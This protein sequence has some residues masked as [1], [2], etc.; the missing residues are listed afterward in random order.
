MEVAYNKDNKERI[1]FEHYL[2][3]YKSADPQEICART[4]IQYNGEGSYFCLKFLG[5]VYHIGY[6][7]FSITPEAGEGQYFPLLSISAARTLVIRYIL[8]GCRA[9][10]TGKYLTY[11][12]V[13]WGEVYYRQFNG[14]CMMR[15]AYSYG[16][17]LDAFCSAMEKLGAHS[18]NAGDA[19]YEIEVFD[20]Y[21]IRFQLWGG[22]EEFPPSSQILFS[23]NFAAAFH[24][25]DLVVACDVIIS[26]MKAV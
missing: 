10:S 26:A 3:E 19:G 24:A 25:E 20:G 13:P 2:A 9:E 8:E 22:D 21:F 5:K 16:N 14:R 17:H 11:R 12:E 4:E 6:P 23:D 7:D 18:I 1:P 15:L